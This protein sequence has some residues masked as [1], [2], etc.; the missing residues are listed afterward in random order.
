MDYR[1][2]RGGAQVLMNALAR[3][4]ATLGRVA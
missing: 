3:S 1:F 2:E 4:A